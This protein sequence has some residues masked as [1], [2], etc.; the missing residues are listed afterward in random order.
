M[1]SAFIV[2]VPATEA[3]TPNGAGCYYQLVGSSSSQATTSTCTRSRK[4]RRVFINSIAPPGVSPFAVPN[5]GD[6]WFKVPVKNVE[7]I[8]GKVLTPKL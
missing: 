6:R 2:G 5:A 7:A 1:K 4:Y 3:R 8:S